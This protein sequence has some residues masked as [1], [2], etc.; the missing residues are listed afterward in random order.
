MSE[1]IHYDK[2][3]AEKLT[4]IYLTSDVVKQ[5]RLVRETLSIKSDEHILDIGSGA[6]LL[7]GE[8]APSLTDGGSI[9][10]VDISEAMVEYAQENYAHLPQVKFQVSDATLLPFPDNT[11][12]AIVSVQVYE[13]IEDFFSCLEELYRV[14]KP[15]G[16]AVLVCTDW[17]TLLWNTNDSPRMQR[18]LEV[19]EGHC[20][21]PQMPRFLASSLRSLGFEILG[22]SVYAMLNLDYHEDTYSHGII[23]FIRIYVSDKAELSSSE[24][25]AWAD[26]LRLKGK[27][28]EY[29]FSLNR[30]FFQIM[31]P[32]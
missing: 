28:G 29:F 3:W 18:V 5:R 32:S 11:F 6:G 8:I 21:H 20:A 4:Q 9:V 17:K 2:A 31:K 19:W 23:D 16:R 14:L 30:Y 12:D 24:A 26:E 7:V 10:G 15:S 25:Q 1:G 27:Q 13:Y 22:G